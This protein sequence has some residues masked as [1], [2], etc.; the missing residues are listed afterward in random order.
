MGALVAGQA[1]VEDQPNPQ[2]DTMVAQA[3]FTNRTRAQMNQML[4]VAE[5]QEQQH[6]AALSAE[7]FERRY[8]GPI[9]TSAQA[10]ADAAIR[11]EINARLGA[12][13][14][15]TADMPQNAAGHPIRN[16][17]PYLHQRDAGD[18][19]MNQAMNGASAKFS[20]P[21][22]PSEFPMAQR[23]ELPGASKDTPF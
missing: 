23:P 9:T 5:Q 7:E 16:V 22:H 21:R 14:I 15:P 11:Q 12:I 19:I 3:A 17:R 4:D 10:A 20:K 8:G 2:Y 1:G 13:P 18:A 6:R